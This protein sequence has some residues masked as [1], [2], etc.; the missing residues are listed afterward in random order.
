MGG[1]SYDGDWVNDAFHGQGRY[2]WKNGAFYIGAW[3]KNKCVIPSPLLHPDFPDGCVGS[4]PLIY[5]ESCIAE[6]CGLQA[7]SWPQ[8][9]GGAN[10]P[11]WDEG[12]RMHG[13]GTFTDME[14]RHWKGQFYNGQ[15]PGLHT[16]ENK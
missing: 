4:S 2:Q 8:V 10:L 13:A 1:D 16:L 6:P 11:S 15:G 14:G 9:A 3:E 7:Q 12:R 5:R